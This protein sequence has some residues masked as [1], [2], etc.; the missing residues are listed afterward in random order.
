MNNNHAAATTGHSGS[1]DLHKGPL[2]LQVNDRNGVT[3]CKTTITQHKRAQLR[4]VLAPYGQDLTL[5]VES[6]YNWYWIVDELQRLGVTVLLGHAR[7]V[8]AQRQGKHKSDAK[9]AANMSQMVRMGT[10][11]QAYACPPEQRSTRDLLRKRLRLV[12]ERTRHLLHSEGVADQYLLADGP[13]AAAGY[14]R[15]CIADVDKV[16]EVDLRIQNL[17]TAEI[18]KLD[19]WLQQR[20]RIHDQGLYDLLTGVRGIGPVL[21]LTFMYEIVDIARFRGPQ[22]FSSYSRV[23][24]PQCDSAGKRLGPGDRR[25]GNPYLCRAFNM[26]AIQSVRTQPPIAAWYGTMV[27]RKGRRTARRVLAHKW[28]VAMYFIWKRREPFNV[29]KFLGTAYDQRAQSTY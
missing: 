6:T 20:A 14:S 18:D 1:V 22:Q 21:A 7:D 8:H 5:G 11:P 12:E 24:N 4:A 25:R 19:K 17:L 28:A 13:M 3:V 2:C 16:L 26:L 15:Q 27:K 29:N 10:F 23:V 9:D